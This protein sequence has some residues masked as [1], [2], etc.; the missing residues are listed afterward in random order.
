MVRWWVVL[1][2]L[3]LFLSLAH[4]KFPPLLTQ[5]SSAHLFQHFSICRSPTPFTPPH[6]QM[7]LICISRSPC[8]WSPTA[9]ACPLGKAQLVFGMIS[10]PSP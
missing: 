3:M 9:H 8:A 2:S 5:C 10:H 6:L 4:H 7:F 1:N